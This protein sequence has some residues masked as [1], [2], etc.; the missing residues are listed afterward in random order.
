MDTLVIWNRSDILD[1]FGHF[2]KFLG[3]FR[4]E[5]FRSDILAPFGH[6][7]KCFGHFLEEILQI[8]ILQMIQCGHLGHFEHV[9]FFGPF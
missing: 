1:P 8:I 2:C 9:R 3:H 4:E 7:C 6:F 5:I